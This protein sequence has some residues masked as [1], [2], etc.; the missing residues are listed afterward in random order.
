MGIWDGKPKEESRRQACSTAALPFDFVPIPLGSAPSFFRSASILVGYMKPFLG[1]SD[2]LD[3]RE[4]RRTAV[5]SCW[6][7]DI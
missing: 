5:P 7:G 4:Y 6:C 1:R 3:S 2:C